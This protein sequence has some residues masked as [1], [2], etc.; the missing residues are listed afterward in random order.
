[1]DGLI[2]AAFVSG[3]LGFLGGLFALY[4]SRRNRRE[5]EAHEDSTPE[6]PTTQQVWD[7]LDRVERRDTALIRIL[8]DVVDQLPDGFRPLV[9]KADVDELEDTL[10]RDFRHRVRLRPTAATN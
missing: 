7:R 3:G 1:M 6:R 9:N 8:V 4:S 10:P 5:S 2:I